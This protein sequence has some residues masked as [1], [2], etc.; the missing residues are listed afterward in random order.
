YVKLWSRFEYP[1]GDES[2]IKLTV[3]VE[4][5][6]IGVSSDQ[7]ELIF[8]AFEQQKGQSSA[9]YGGTG[10]GLTITQRLVELLN[11]QIYMEDR[12]GGGSQFYIVFDGVKVMH[13]ED[14]N[15]NQ[16]MSL[17]IQ[18]L[19]FFPAKILIADDDQLNRD[20]IK[21][22]L[23]QYP[24]SVVEAENGLQAVEQTKAQRP[25]LILM[26]LKMP[27]MDGIEASRKIH[28]ISQFKDIP[29]IAVTASAMKDSLDKTK[30]FCR[31]V[32]IKPV[33]K[34]KLLAEMA[35]F[36]PHEIIPDSTK[37]NTISPGKKELMIDKLTKKQITKLPELISI[38]DG[39]LFKRWEDLIITL[40]IKDILGFALEIQ[41]LG[42]KYHLNSLT[43][44][45]DKLYQEAK[46]FDIESLPG[47]L[48]KY[49]SFIQEFKAHIS[50]H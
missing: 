2:L 11:G 23:D 48:K 36:L 10:L 46:L 17:S 24:L 1:E 27:V 40:T 20:V 6:G 26:D 50:K 30:D 41:E 22:Y 29:I 34:E 31:S 19:N 32:I 3:V 12:E 45:G 7:K 25:D 47:T 21:G 42:K 4:D 33:N 14:F 43:A 49:P 28:D 5:T 8:N 38:L 16:R 37:D 9:K 39:A 35:H 18:M 15:K 13:D 44:W